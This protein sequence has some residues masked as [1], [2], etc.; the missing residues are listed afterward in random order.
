MGNSATKIKCHLHEK[1]ELHVKKSAKN[2]EKN[3]FVIEILKKR[4]KLIIAEKHK[5]LKNGISEN[6][7]THSSNSHFE[8]AVCLGIVGK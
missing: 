6:H 8:S 2:D 5:I 4:S 1:T 7:E 3:F